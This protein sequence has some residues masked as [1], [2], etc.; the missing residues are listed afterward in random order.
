MFCPYFLLY[1]KN[2]SLLSLKQDIYKPKL[3]NGAPFRQGA[4]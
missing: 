4:L 1:C 2:R 3:D